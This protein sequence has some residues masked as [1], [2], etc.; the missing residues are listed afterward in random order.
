[1]DAGEAAK[2][3]QSL[4]IPTIIARP[5]APEAPVATAS[6]EPP[7]PRFA[8]PAAG[9]VRRG[10]TARGRTSDYHDGI[11]LAAPEGTAVRATAEGKVLFA[12]NEPRQFGNLVVVDHGQ[13]WQSSYAFLSRIT[14][15]QGE[16]V[17]QG[18][19]VGLSGHTGRARGSEL[20]FELR[21][22]NRPLDPAAQLPARCAT[23]P[24]PRTPCPWRETPPASSRSRSPARANLC[25]GGPGR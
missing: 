15:K 25:R 4:L 5:A 9:N 23:N 8:W 18:E 14:V 11:D 13:G 19:R 16:Q 22:D 24:A 2:N 3:G 7:R 6:S 10:F 21:R 12:G 17:R 1:M 20:H